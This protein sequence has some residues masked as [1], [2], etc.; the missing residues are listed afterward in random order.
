MRTTNL[1]KLIEILPDNQ[2]WAEQT[3][4]ER[5]N[6]LKKALPIAM[7]NLTP[8]QQKYIRCYFYDELTITETA[9]LYNIAPSTVS[10]TIARGKKKL[11]TILQFAL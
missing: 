1:G 2:I 6:R 3:N 11:K 10:R 5:L 9:K 7:E 8:T 4:E